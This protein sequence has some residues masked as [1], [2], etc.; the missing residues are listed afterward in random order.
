MVNQKITECN[1]L[2]FRF[3]FKFH[4]HRDSLV[5]FIFV[6]YFCS[7]V[8]LSLYARLL[9]SS[10]GFYVV[11]NIVFFGSVVLYILMDSAAVQKL[12][13]PVICYLVITILFLLTYL[14]HPEYEP[15]FFE[16]TYGIQIQFFRGTGGIWAFL[17]IFLTSDRDKL[18][19]YL[20]WVSWI[21]FVFLIFRFMTA[22][23]RGYWISYG[24]NYEQM[25]R[26]YNLGFG[27]SMLFPVL[28]FATEA[29][30][31][32][33]KKY[34][35]PFVLGAFMVLAGGSRGA[36][37]WVVAC[38]LFMLP[39][40]W[41]RMSKRKRCIAVVVLAFL[42]PFAILVYLYY[43]LLAQGILLFLSNHNISSRTL[44][45]LLTGEFSEANGRDTIYEMVIQRIK[46]GGFLGNGVFG[47]RVVVGQR[48]RW[49]YAH[50]IFLELYA[51]FGYLG[52]TIVS[53]VLICGCIVTA[54]NCR[55]TR[56]QMIFTTCLLSSMKLILS[57]SFWFNSSFW[58]LLAIMIL[59]RRQDIH[60]GLRKG[61]IVWKLRN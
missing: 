23:A 48:Y 13:A 36:F 3:R 49:G 17:V 58:M 44:T 33:K 61:R 39:Y 35:I 15:W 11:Y 10:N 14:I 45:T 26:D 22:Q 6:F 55:E 16:Q 52:G 43:D 60:M 37:I 12:T 21:L 8:F 51:A 20:R 41:H 2:A 19:K 50:N 5:A 59:W 29:F 32:E 9:G 56:D 24:A 1:H 4:L 7:D 57:D 34:Y 18:L 25:E 46:E 27:Y 42:L 30:L 31:N 28:F 38:F 53:I 40:K 54:K 47:E